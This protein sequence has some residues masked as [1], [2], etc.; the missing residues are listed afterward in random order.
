MN[1]RNLKYSLLL[2]AAVFINSCTT[3]KPQVKN[4]STAKKSQVTKPVPPKTPANPLPPAGTDVIKVTLPEINREFRAAWIATV[5]NIN[6]P[7]RN[8]LTTQQ[9]K[10]EAIQLLDM[11]K[12]AN[13]NA[14]IFQ[15]RPSADAMYKSDLEPWSYFLTGQTGKAPSPYYDPL[16]F[17]IEEAH[18]RGMELHVWMNPYRAHHT[19]GGAVTSSSM[20]SVM[21][22]SVYKLRN[23][24]YWM[25]PS[26]ERVQNHVS[27]V[28]KDLVKRYDID[29]V[30]IDDYFYP[31]KEYHGGR[32]FPDDKTWNMYR[33]SGGTLSRADWRRANVNKII[34]RLHDEIHAEKATVKFGIS[35]FG[36]WKPGY[37]AGV[38]GSSQYDELYADAKLWLNEGWCDY[39]S[40]QL[41]WKE[42]GAQ[43]FSALLK[44][45]KDENIKNIHLWPGLNTVGVKADN[46]PNEITGQ[47]NTIRRMLPKNGAGE[48]HYSTDGLKKSPEMLSAVKKLYREDALVPATPWI[49]TKKI[50]TP[51][52][53]GA[54]SGDGYRVNWDSKEN[55]TV[56]RWVLFARYGDTW[57]T[58]ILDRDHTGKTLPL[59]RNGKK[60]NTVAI[61]AIDRLSNESD[62][63]AVKL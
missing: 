47:M 55:G 14:V 15:V 18:K 25:D 33:N 21:S 11:L 58:K 63:D 59:T 2:A 22:Q 42:G 4:R 9:Q 36:I 1:I 19:T 37:P 52:L 48:I 35:P 49:K 61:K 17:W 43:S 53:S 31:Y 7:T 30:H 10:D 40:P 32:D 6:W 46:K 13:F 54:K 20:A 45:W 44:W 41:Y 56:F 50:M 3:Q 24:M 23:G 39:Y 12:G 57:E 8:N 60:L 27:S 38:T 29:A 5:A 16:E 28:I 34:K 62:Y 26:D 51:T